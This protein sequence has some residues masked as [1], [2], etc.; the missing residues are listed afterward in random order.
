MRALKWSKVVLT[1]LALVA[2]GCADDAGESS[3]GADTDATTN[4]VTTTGAPR[5]GGILTFAEFSEPASLDPLV[6]TGSGTTGAT[7]MAAVFDTIMR[8]DPATKQYEGRTAES[9]TSSPDSLEWTIKLRPGIHFSDGTAYDATAVAFGLN[10]HRSGQPGAPPCAEIVACPRNGTSSGVYMELVKDIQV[11]DPLTVKVMLREPWTAFQFALSD[12]PGMIPSPTALKKACTEPTKP[13]RDCSFGLAPVGAGPFVLD[14]FKPKE[15]ITMSRNAAYWGG[16]VHLDGLQFLSRQDSGGDQTYDAF[17]AGLVQV[18]YLR[19]P[20]TVAKSKDDKFDGITEFNHGGGLLLFNLGV[21]VTCAG[22]KPDPVCTGKPDGPTPSSPPTAIL[23]VRQAIAAAI[24]PKVIDERA[25]DGKG[26]P[27]SELIQKDFPWYPGPLNSPKY[28]PALAKRLT[29]EAKAEGWDG[30]VRMLYNSSPLAIDVAL[31]IEAMLKAVGIDVQ[32]DVSKDV[33][34]HVL[35][36]SNQRDFDISGW[37]TSI[38]GDDGASAS[39]A[40]NLGST[41]PSNRVGYKNPIVDQALKDFR[42]AK[43]DAGKTA[44]IKVIMEQVYKDLPYYGWSTVEARVVY[45]PKVHGIVANHSSAV[46][47]HQAWLEA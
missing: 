15:G 3:D 13:I 31:S 29:D 47:F 17:K 4:G 1:A 14:S 46:F 9:V 41:S 7:E 24:N 16:E 2:A 12:E 19:S 42:A 26:L 33:T 27:G 35:Q 8:Y 20:S 18:A 23:K 11:V 40:Q 36:V 21:P 37:G 5:R 22:G 34:A 39:L 38:A 45:S 10:R 6:S 32:V 44:A 43:D 28:D 25:N 30:R